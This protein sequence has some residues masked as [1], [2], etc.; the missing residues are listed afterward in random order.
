M[1]TAHDLDSLG[2]KL[3]K[4]YIDHKIEL[5]DNLAKTATAEGLNQHQTNR[6]AEAANIE[7]YLTLMKT[8][9]DK[10]I[11]FPLADPKKA[12][13]I[14]QELEKEA[15]AVVSDDYKKPFINT[16]VPEVFNK[17]ASLEEIE[18]SKDKEI[19]KSESEWRKEASENLGILQ[20]L[21][22][23]LFEANSSFE[24]NYL[25]LKFLVKQAMLQGTS[26][27]D[28]KQIIKVAAN[29]LGNQACVAIQEDLK[30]DLIH[31][32]FEKEAQHHTSPNPE[33]K[34]FKVAQALSS[35]VGRHGQLQE[36][37]AYYDAKYN[38]LLKKANLPSMYK[39]AAGPS[40]AIGKLLANMWAFGKKHKGLAVTVPALGAVYS[41]GK[42]KGKAEQGSILQQGYVKLGPTK[43]PQK[44]F[45]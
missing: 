24:T 28:I 34:I 1:F 10:Y 9:K 6:V 20:C 43:N 23:G 42:Q 41:F 22:N 30:N 2:K 15:T 8:A 21:N 25:K 13:S 26:Y 27:N 33:S 16:T 19:P 35:N 37:I 11:D 45:R 32:S 44:I 18:R 7:S 3:S 39:Q 36:A 4:D 12:F 29:P 40:T 17:F 14:G 5:T 31:I 38:E